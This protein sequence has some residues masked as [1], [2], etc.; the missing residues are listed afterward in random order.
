MIWITL[1]Q[2][3]DFLKVSKM[4]KNLLNAANE[5][6]LGSD[7]WIDEMRIVQKVKYFAKDEIIN[8]ISDFDNLI[9]VCDY[10]D[11]PYSS[12]IFIYG[13]LHEKSCN[14]YLVNNFLN[15]YNHDIESFLNLNYASEKEKYHKNDL[16]RILLEN[17]E[18]NNLKLDDDVSFL[19]AFDIFI[20]D[21]IENI[22]QNDYM[23]DNEVRTILEL[24]NNLWDF[25]R[26]YGD[27]RDI[28]D[29]I[30]ILPYNKEKNI[31]GEHYNDKIYFGYSSFIIRG[32]PNTYNYINSNCEITFNIKIQEIIIRSFTIDNIYKIF[33]LK[34]SI[35][36]SIIF[37]C[38][39]KGEITSI[40]F[41]GLDLLEFKYPLKIGANI[42]HQSIILK[43][44]RNIN[45]F[46]ECL[47]DVI[48]NYFK[49]NNEL[50]HNSYQFTTNVI[51]N[52]N[53]LII[54]NKHN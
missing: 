3:P 6:V 39:V 31:M 28:I 24:Y 42:E 23:M 47:D 29:E 26:L 41:N 18:N 36:F 50:Y 43:N 54:E 16:F 37:N 19:R 7:E 34:N 35:N 49:H 13:L 5:L 44:N 25:V 15:F 51:F 46:I 22:L 48:N 10:W 4:G 11:L 32:N 40:N 30:P 14:T 33:A 17:Y 12:S 1:F 53:N 8:N 2:I 20:E 38:V 21:N 27:R 9:K 45:K 52:E